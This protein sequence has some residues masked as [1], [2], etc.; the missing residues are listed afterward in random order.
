VRF[1]D[2]KGFYS[3]H[4]ENALF[5]AR[6]FYRTTA[7]VKHLGGSGGSAGLPSVTLNRALYET[8]LKDLL[9]DGGQ[10]SVEL[11]E[12]YGAHWKVVR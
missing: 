9:L 5:V 11:W 8:V 10:H 12:G 7:V 4:G 2:R 3:V 1:F 6:T